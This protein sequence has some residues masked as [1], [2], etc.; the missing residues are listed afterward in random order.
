MATGTLL[1]C[2][3]LE[4]Q[5]HAGETPLHLAVRAARYSQV[6][7]DAIVQDPYFRAFVKWACITDNH[8]RT[9]SRLTILLGHHGIA[10]QVVLLE[11]EPKSRTITLS[12]KQAL[13]DVAVLDGP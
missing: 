8:G 10:K 6:A 9:V 2:S 5:N 11:V 13:L 12:E 7:F 1:R 4:S 3:L